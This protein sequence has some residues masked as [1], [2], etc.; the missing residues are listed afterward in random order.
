MVKFPSNVRK[1]PQIPR[2]VVD[3]F[4]D[5]GSRFARQ[6]GVEG[7]LQNRGDVPSRFDFKFANRLGS[8]KPTILVGPAAPRI[9][10][11]RF[12]LILSILELVLF[13][14]ALSCATHGDMR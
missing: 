13:S 11:E 1:V 9:S 14:L 7:L 10:Q 5:K 3:I 2:S 4:P 8:R 12:L 6:I